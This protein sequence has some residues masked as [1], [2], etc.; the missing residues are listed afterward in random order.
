MLLVLHLTAEGMVTRPSYSVLSPNHVLGLNSCSSHF[1]SVSSASFISQCVWPPVRLVRF[2]PDYFSDQVI[3][4]M[5]S[6][7]LATD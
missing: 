4:C 6:L 2:L 5:C 1:D 7:S 3:R